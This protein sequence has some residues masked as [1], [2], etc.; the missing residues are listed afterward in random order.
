M[1]LSTLLV[2]LVMIIVVRHSTLTCLI[3][4]PDMHI[5]FYILL[6]GII[7]FLS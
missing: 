4:L 7:I 6:G 5:K 2:S 3:E 1:V